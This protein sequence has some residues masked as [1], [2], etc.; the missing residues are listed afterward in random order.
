MSPEV[1]RFLGQLI[2]AVVSGGVVV[3]VINA[4]LSPKTRAE[5][6]QIAQKTAQESIDQALEHLRADLAD[7]RLQI[8]S[9]VTRADAAEQKADQ[10]EANLDAIAAR[11]R[12]LVAYL[13]DLMAWT[14]R[15]YE[16]GHPPGM[17]P[18]PEPPDAFESFP[19]P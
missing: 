14:K 7:A 19:K 17:K 5:T 13:W 18:P 16:A 6:R 1:L 2:L 4:F 3:A 10:A 15:Y 12:V 9:A 11:D 8:T